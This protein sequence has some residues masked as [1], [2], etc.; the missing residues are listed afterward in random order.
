M[1]RV[2]TW[3]LFAV[4]AVTF[5][6]S[7]LTLF[8]C[9]AAAAQSTVEHP[10]I[11]ECGGPMAAVVAERAASIAVNHVAGGGT[12]EELERLI[13]ADIKS[14]AASEGK[15]FVTCLIDKALNAHR[16]PLATLP[17]RHR[18]LM[19]PY[20]SSLKAF[21]PIDS[22]RFVPLEREP[23]HGR[24]WHTLLAGARGVRS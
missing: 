11:I 24:P 4:L 20:A 13:V 15:G 12:T 16:S 1:K 5:A 22:N 23:G 10:D 18:V 2:C 9:G 17:Q 19:P 3:P 6:L 7:S 14:I 8:G 21:S